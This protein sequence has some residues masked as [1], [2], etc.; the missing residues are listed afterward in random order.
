MYGSTT[1]RSSTSATP[2]ARGFRPVSSTLDLTLAPTQPVLLQGESGFSQK[3]ADARHASYYYS[4][5]QLA[6]SGSVERG[7]RSDTVSGTAWLDHEWSSAYLPQRAVGW[8]WTVSTW[9]TALR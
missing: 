6:V 3:A 5:P 7:G 8:D 9:T 1:G 4:Q 2:T